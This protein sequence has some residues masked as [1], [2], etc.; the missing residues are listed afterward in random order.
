MFI[1]GYDAYAD[2]VP[3]CRPDHPDVAVL[4][5]P[6]RPSAPFY[7]PNGAAGSP[8]LN[9]ECFLPVYRQQGRD[10]VAFLRAHPGQFFGA[11]FTGVQFFFEPALDIVFTPHNLHALHGLDTAYAWTLFPRV[12]LKPAFYSEWGGLRDLVN[13]GIYLIPTVVVLDV[14]AVLLAVGAIRRLIRQRRRV[15]GGSGRQRLALYAAVG[16]TCAWV[17]AIGSAFEINENARYRLLIEPFL[18]LL[19]ARAGEL[20]YHAARRRLRPHRRNPTPTPAQ[21]VRAT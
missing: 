5:D 13:G 16:L 6:Q 15:G 11:Q 14:A 4:A 9:Y 1:V 19:L 7:G 10:A 21:A 2:A 12:L 20:A 18:L 17:T 3:P 8:N